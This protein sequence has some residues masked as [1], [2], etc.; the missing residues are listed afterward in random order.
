VARRGFL[1]GDLGGLTGELAACVALTDLTSISATTDDLALLAALGE[2]VNL[3]RYW[4][5]PDGEDRALSDPAVRE[6]LLP[7]ARVVAGD[8]PRRQTAYPRLH[9]RCGRL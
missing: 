6:A 7:V 8:R 4:G 2:P 9:R 3:A 5:P 1:G